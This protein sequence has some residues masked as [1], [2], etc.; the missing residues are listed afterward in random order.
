MSLSKLW[1]LVMDREAWCAVVHGGHEDRTWLSDWTELNGDTDIEN[2]LVITVG[3]GK[4]RTNWESSY[5]IQNRGL[6]G[7]SVVKNPPANTDATGDAGSIPGSGRSSGGGNGNPLQYSGQE[8][9]M[10]RWAWWTIVHGVTKSWMWLS[11]WA[12]QQVSDFHPPL[13]PE[14]LVMMLA[15]FFFLKSNSV[16]QKMQISYPF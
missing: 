8:N 9:S 7:G 14:E 13:P 5:N 3:E 11:D 2:G 15:I 1:G 12:F 10:D 16:P 4:G 6:P